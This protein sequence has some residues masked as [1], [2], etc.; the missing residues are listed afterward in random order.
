MHCFV[1]PY[2]NPSQAQGI[3]CA[4]EGRL[5]SPVMMLGALFGLMASPAARVPLVSGFIVIGVPLLTFA[6]AAPSRLGLVREL[7][8][9]MRGLEAALLAGLCVLGGRRDD[10]AAVLQRQRVRTENAYAAA[11]GRLGAIVGADPLRLHHVRRLGLFGALLTVVAGNALPLLRPETYTWGDDFTALAVVAFDVL[12]VGLV[13]RVVTERMAIRLLEATHALG[14][15]RPVTARLRVVP[16]S[17][18][19][20]AAMGAVGSL[21]VLAAMAAASALE[22]SWIVDANLVAAGFWFIRETAPLALPLGIGVG[23]ILGA[24]AGLAQ[25]PLPE[26]RALTT[27]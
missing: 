22:S 21:V 16:L 24:G 8:L 12:V 15:G 2:D 9:L 23:A 5:F 13:A 4:R 1:S 7:G 25:P 27:Q 11:H 26:E 19:L 10:A 3:A 17:T 14:G 18:T 6:V 20:G